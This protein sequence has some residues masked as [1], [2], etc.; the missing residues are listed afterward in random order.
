MKPSHYNIY[1]PMG[2]ELD[3]VLYN[4]LSG[5]LFRVN[6]R[7]IEA[8][9][10][11]REEQLNSWFVQELKDN[12]IWVEDGVDERAIFQTLHERYKYSGTRAY[13]CLYVTYRCNMACQYCYLEYFMKG[14]SSELMGVETARAVVELAK[15]TVRDNSCTELVTVFTGGEPLINMFAIHEVLER[16]SVWAKAT[17]IEFRGI[18]FSNGTAPTEEIVDTL[19][20][21]NLFFQITLSGARDIHD[22]KRPFRGGEGTYE[23]VIKTLKLFRERQ[24]AFG[25][26]VDV[27]RENYASISEMLDDLRERVGEGLYIKFFPI[28]PGAEALSL[29]WTSYCLDLVELGKL[30]ALWRLARA[31]EFR[32]MLNPLIKYVYCDYLTNR[33]YIVDPVGDVYKCGGAVGVKERR[34]G[35]LDNLGRIQ[36]VSAQYYDWMSRSPLTV[37]KCR[38]CK[39]LPACGGGCAGVAY[40]KHKTYHREDCRE[41]YLIKERIKFYLEEVQDDA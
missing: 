40:D 9:Q 11:V 31:K 24:V 2:E 3:Y 35:T 23:D 30:S 7:A 16:L 17:D 29:P 4:T 38:N 13:L 10:K 6:R 25:I 36:E 22:K 21:Y 15:R 19:S 41:K 34:I 14:K 27:D 33:G 28:I 8:I 26:R 39:F 12:R 37:G 5:A 1:I 20:K 18:I 32:V